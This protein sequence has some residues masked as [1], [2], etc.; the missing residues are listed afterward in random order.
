MNS[1]KKII[2]VIAV[3]ALLS[4]TF[5]SAEVDGDGADFGDKTISIGKFTDMNNGTLTAYISNNGSDAQTIVLVVKDLDENVKASTTVTIEAGAVNKEVSVSFGYDTSG[6]KYVKV[7]IY[8][9]DG[10]TKINTIGPL[11]INVKHSIWKDWVTYLVVVIIIVVIL[12][13]AYFYIRGAPDRAAKKEAKALES[14]TT[15]GAQKTKYN[16][17]TERKS[18]R[19]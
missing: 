15:K 5:L 3:C 1:Y 19:K 2:G 13:L 12:V 11:E 8:E 10:T 14:K 4:F 9:E 16:A 6:G 7:Y 18:K 17:G